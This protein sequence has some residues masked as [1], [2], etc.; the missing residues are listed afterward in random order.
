MRPSPT[1]SAAG[2][3]PAAASG[4]AWTGTGVATTAVGAAGVGV[5]DP[6]EKGPEIMS[7]MHEPRQLSSSELSLVLSSLLG[8]SFLSV[9]RSLGTRC[10]SWMDGR[11]PP[12]SPPCAHA[13]ANPRSAISTHP[14]TIRLV[15]MAASL[16][17]P[18]ALSSPRRARPP[19][20]GCQ[21][22]L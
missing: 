21:C 11:G 18:E 5:S 10:L 8:L 20:L 22:T 7:P 12:S 3:P 15:G 16:C 19:L 6:K 1:T 14:G 9:S 17:D 2:V 4:T 13:G